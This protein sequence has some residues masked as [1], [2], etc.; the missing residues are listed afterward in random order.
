MRAKKKYPK[1]ETEKYLEQVKMRESYIDEHFI[2][3]TGQ[4]NDEP[5]EKSLVK[6]AIS[7]AIKYGVPPENVITQKNILQVNLSNIAL[8]IFMKLI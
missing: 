1:L 6:T 7:L 2:F 4:L 5:C 8:D 3:S